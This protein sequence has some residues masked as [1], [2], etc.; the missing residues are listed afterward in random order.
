MATHS[1]ILAWR[2]PWV[3][4]PGGLQSM[5]VTM[6]RTHW[7]TDAPR[8]S[9][10]FAFHGISWSFS[11]LSCR[12]HILQWFL[13]LS[14]IAMS[15]QDRD[16]MLYILY[17]Y[18]SY[19][20]IG[21][22]KISGIELVLGRWRSYARWIPEFE[23]VLILHTTVVCEEKNVFGTPCEQR[24]QAEGLGLKEFDSEVFLERV[25][26]PWKVKYDLTVYEAFKVDNMIWW[27]V[28]KHKFW[29]ENLF[30]LIGSEKC[31]C[32]REKKWVT[33]GDTSLRIFKWVPVTDSKEVSVEENQNNKKVTSSF[34]L[35]F[36]DCF[37]AVMGFISPELSWKY[38]RDLSVI[39]PYKASHFIR[40]PLLPVIPFS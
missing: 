27:E 32:F 16:T 6:S 23:N 38:F 14:F 34:F 1:S 22:Y 5:G 8:V 36:F 40:F 17:P 4:E 9:R 37:L 31:L 18:I 2:I 21:L 26:L 19:F 30:Y 25:I 33:V 28:E 29:S 7:V 15:S 11:L 20:I 12:L 24:W 13:Y 10:S 3:E 39:G 35:S